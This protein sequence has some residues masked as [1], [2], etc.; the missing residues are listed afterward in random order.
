MTD[1]TATGAAGTDV[2]RFAPARITGSNFDDRLSVRDG[3][4]DGGACTVLGRNGNDTITGSPYGDEFTGGAGDDNIDG[5][6]GVNQVNYDG[7]TA[8]N[9]NLPNGREPG[10]APTPSRRFSGWWV[11]AAT[12][13][14]SR[15]VGP[16]AAS[17]PRR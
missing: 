11:P 8:V 6:G 16:T 15:M 9:V 7:P 2:L 13:R 5:K 1:R 4:G 3:N 10:K 14:S 17:C 12:T